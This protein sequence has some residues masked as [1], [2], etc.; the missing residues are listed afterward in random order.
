[1]KDLLAVII[2]TLSLVAI[3]IASKDSYGQGYISATLDI[4][5][6]RINK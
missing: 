4:W 1:M 2:I 6:E 3:S 5:E